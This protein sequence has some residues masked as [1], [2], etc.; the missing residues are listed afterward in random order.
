M[1]NKDRPGGLRP[2]KYLNGSPWN[3]QVRMYYCN[4]TS[5]SAIYK[6]SCVVINADGADA[7]GY[8][9]GC[10]LAGAASTI[11]GVAVGFSNTR[12]IAAD[13]TSLERAYCPA[14]TAMYVAVVDDPNVIFEVQ[15]DNASAYM[16]AAAVGNTAVLA[17][18]S[19]GST[20]TGRSTAELDSSDAGQTAIASHPLLVIGRVDREDNDFGSSA[21][22]TKWLVTIQD[23]QFKTGAAGV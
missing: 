1:A 23:H 6:G 16:T 8:S 11:L 9:M 21:S 20:T 15:E 18:H 19:G 10:D 4:G 22:Y 13:V 5:T 12:K 3:G 7:T 2:V 14:S 17:G